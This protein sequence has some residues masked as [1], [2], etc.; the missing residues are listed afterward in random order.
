V[1]ASLEDAAE[2]RHPVEKESQL[3]RDPRQRDEDERHGERDA[4]PIRTAPR[5]ARDAVPVRDEHRQ[6]RRQQHTRCSD[7]VDRLGVEVSLA[8]HARP[9]HRRAQN[10]REHCR[11]ASEATG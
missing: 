9:E 6:R 11:D 5:P 4:K 7:R 10:R 8:D 2:N 3:R 1:L